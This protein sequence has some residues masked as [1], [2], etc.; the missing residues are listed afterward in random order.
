MALD[1]FTVMAEKQT[2]KKLKKIQYDNEFQ[3][4]LWKN[5]VIEKSVII[6]STVLYSSAANGM[7]EQT[8]GIVFEMV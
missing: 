6:E 8:L 7:A 3:S 2:G 4:D 5:W 1:Q